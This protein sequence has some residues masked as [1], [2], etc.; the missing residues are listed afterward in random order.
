[1]HIDT[2]PTTGYIHSQLLYKY[3]TYNNEFYNM[4]YGFSTAVNLDEDHVRYSF[5]PV[6]GNIKTQLEPSF[7]S[8]DDKQNVYISFSV[9]LC[10]PAQP[11]DIARLTQ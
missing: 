9:S 4:S 8:M 3:K 7:M 2:L 6:G 10:P 11:C 1:M 5:R